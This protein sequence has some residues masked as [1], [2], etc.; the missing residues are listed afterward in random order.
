MAQTLLSGNNGKIEI[1]GKAVAAVK[2][3]SVDI[4]SDTI[5]TSTMGVD[6]R[7]YIKGLSSWNGSADIIVDFASDTGN[8]TGTNVISAL[9]GT[10]ALVGDTGTVFTA[11]MDSVGTPAGKKWAGNIIVTG[12]SQTAN[13]D[14]MIEGTIS[15]QGTGPITYTA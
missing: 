5:E 6:T 8:L 12:F 2:T 4:T 14:G 7:T 13:M 3:F 10:A 9:N 15:F 11:Y 1:A